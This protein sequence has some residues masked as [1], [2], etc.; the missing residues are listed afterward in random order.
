MLS[1][2]FSNRQTTLVVDTDVWKLVLTELFRD[3]GIDRGEISISI[4]DDPE[5]HTLNRQYLHHDYATDVLS[6]LLGRHEGELYGEIVVSAQMAR[7]R[8]AEFGWQ[9]VDELIWYAIHGALH[10][11]GYDDKSPTERERMWQ[12]ETHY[13]RR[14][15]LTI[16]AG[17]PAVRRD[18]VASQES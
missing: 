5:I 18:N 11:V 10:L 1:L 3:E 2:E 13:L 7:A 6:F 4:V 14:L 9:A 12:R 17:A 16:P 8:A 15:G